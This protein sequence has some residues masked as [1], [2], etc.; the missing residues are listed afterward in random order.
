MKTYGH[1]R[2]QHST[3][4]A[5]KVVFSE[6]ASTSVPLPLNGDIQLNSEATANGNK[7][8]MRSFLP[9]LRPAAPT[10]FPFSFR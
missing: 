7:T 8:T 2:D 3:N 6:A 5:Q 1:L 4:M 9:P 10:V